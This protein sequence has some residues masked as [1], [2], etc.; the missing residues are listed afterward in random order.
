MKVTETATM[1]LH[2]W[3]SPCRTMKL[4]KCAISGVL[5]LMVIAGMVSCSSAESVEEGL[6]PFVTYENENP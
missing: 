2:R 6:A 1:R 3:E 5:I 4:G